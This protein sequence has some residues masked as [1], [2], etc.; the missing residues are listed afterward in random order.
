MKYT[1]SMHLKLIQK[2]SN[3]V[4]RIAEA[5]QHLCN[6]S[7]K[8]TESPVKKALFLAVSVFT[9]IKTL[10]RC[11]CWNRD[12]RDIPI[13][14]IAC[15]HTPALAEWKIKLFLSIPRFLHSWLKCMIP[16]NCKGHSK[17]DSNLFLFTIFPGCVWWACPRWV[18][19]VL[20]ETSA[21]S[22]PLAVCSEADEITWLRHSVELRACLWEGQTST[23]RRCA[24]KTTPN[25]FLLSEARNLKI[26]L[27]GDMRRSS[28]CFYFPSYATV[29]K[30]SITK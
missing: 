4:W 30:F 10:G 15:W 23:D 5:K 20:V 14:H 7:A 16:Q 17:G 21:V 27:L 19:T 13:I 18:G 9:S 24:W 2:K 1:I 11:I 6:F 29:T 12:L 25:N 3:W 8:Q 28:F 26:F 22:L